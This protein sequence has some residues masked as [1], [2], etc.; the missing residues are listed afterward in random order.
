MQ[1]KGEKNGGDSVAIKRGHRAGNLFECSCEFRG[2]FPGGLTSGA[3]WGELE[4][5]KEFE[6][7]RAVTE[8]ELS[9]RAQPVRGESY[10]RT[11]LVKSFAV[12]IAA[13]LPS[14]YAYGGVI[15]FLLLAGQIGTWGRYCVF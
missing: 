8:A 11:V 5:Q 15:T 9:C 2:V 13:P 14:N 3:G 1:K 12:H 4:G 7:E 6:M 10:N